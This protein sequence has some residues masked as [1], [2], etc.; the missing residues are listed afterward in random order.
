MNGRQEE[1]LAA[2]MALRARETQQ[3]GMQGPAV[4]ESSLAPLAAGTL[5]N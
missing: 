3:L 1:F 2:D 5:G 4:H